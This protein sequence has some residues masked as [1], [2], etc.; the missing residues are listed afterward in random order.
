MTVAGRAPCAETS[1]VHTSAAARQV[2]KAI[3]ELAATTTT[4]VRAPPAAVVLFAKISQALIAACVHQ[5]SKAILTY[6]AR[7]S[8]HITRQS[9]GVKITNLFSPL[10]FN[11]FSYLQYNSI[12]FNEPR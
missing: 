4:S 11:A 10:W 7:V 9:L 8:F 2:S 12:A 5:V 1:K 6:T 3:R